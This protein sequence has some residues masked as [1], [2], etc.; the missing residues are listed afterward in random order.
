MDLHLP[1]KLDIPGTNESIWSDP[2]LN[3][4]EDW[5]AAATYLPS[6]QQRQQEPGKNLMAKLT[7]ILNSAVF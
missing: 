5:F 7:C 3:G 6:K 1:H 4:K 2:A